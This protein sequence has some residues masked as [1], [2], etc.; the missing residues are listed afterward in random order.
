L[1]GGKEERRRGRGG[2]ERGGE[3]GGGRE[4][5]E[6]ETREED[7]TLV[8]F[9]HPGVHHLFRTGNSENS[10]CFVARMC[11]QKGN[12]LFEKF[13]KFRT[14]QNSERRKCQRT[15]ERQGR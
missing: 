3:E 12:C 11:I 13:G 6:M 4:G 7:R 9:V 10:F 15:K 2:E 8:H 5:G 1:E 14:C